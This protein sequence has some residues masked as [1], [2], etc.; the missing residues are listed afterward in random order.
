ME[1]FDFKFNKRLESFAP[2][3]SQYILLADFKESHTLLWF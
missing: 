1:F 3:Y 2:S